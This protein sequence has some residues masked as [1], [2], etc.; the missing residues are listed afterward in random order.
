MKT[1]FHLLLLK[2][3]AACHEGQP[4]FPERRVGKRADRASFVRRSS[5]FASLFVSSVGGAAIGSMFGLPGTLLG[6]LLGGGLGAVMWR[7]HA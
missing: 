6:A 1:L 4:A 3:G 2:G 7:G 5:R